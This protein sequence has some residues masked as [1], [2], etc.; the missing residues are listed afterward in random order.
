MR[1]KLDKSGKGLFEVHKD[2]MDATYTKPLNEVITE[3]LLTLGFN[4]KSARIEMSLENL[5]TLIQKRFCLTFGETADYYEL[6]ILM[7]ER[8]EN[9]R[10]FR[11]LKEN[12]IVDLLEEAE[13]WAGDL[14]S[15]FNVDREN[16][17]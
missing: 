12:G 3:I 11:T 10:A 8:R 7:S 14:L 17:L 1:I 4:K 5:E 6:Y 13:E 9:L 2:G 16:S 15:Q